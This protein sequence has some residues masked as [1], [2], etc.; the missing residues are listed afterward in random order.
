MKKIIWSLLVAILFA[1]AT[2]ADGYDEYL[3]E[4]IEYETKGDMVMALSNYYDAIAMNPERNEAIERWT[5]IED[6]M[7]EGKPRFGNLTIFDIHD[8][9][10]KN[11]QDFTTFA[12]TMQKPLNISIYADSL[13]QK[14]INY[15]EKN[16][17]YTINYSITYSEKLLWIADVLNKGLRRNEMEYVTTSMFSIQEIEDINSYDLDFWTYEETLAYGKKCLENNNKGNIKNNLYIDTHPVS[18]FNRKGDY[19]K[20][21]KSTRYI[22]QLSFYSRD[23]M[24]IT[25][26]PEQVFTSTV[27]KSPI[28][29]EWGSEVHFMGVTGI[30]VYDFTVDSTFM[31]YIENKDFLVKVEPI[32]LEY[33]IVGCNSIFNEFFEFDR[34][35]TVDIGE[36]F[37]QDEDD[38][39][40]DD[41]IANYRERKAHSDRKAKGW[42]DVGD[43]Y[44]DDQGRAIGLVYEIDEKKNS[45]LVINFNVGVPKSIASYSVKYKKYI[46]IDSKSIPKDAEIISISGYWEN[47]KE[48]NRN[49]YYDGSGYY[50]RDSLSDYLNEKVVNVSQKRKV[51][52]VENGKTKTKTL[53]NFDYTKHLCLIVDDKVVTKIDDIDVKVF[54]S[55]WLKINKD[56]EPFAICNYFDFIEFEDGSSIKIDKRY[57]RL[58]YFSGEEAEL[59]L[60]GK[61]TKQNW[62]ILYIEPGYDIHPG[63]YN[64]FIKSLSQD[65]IDK[66]KIDT[67]EIGYGRNFILG[68][69]F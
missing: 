35:G 17:E 9:W 27:G 34:L 18:V 5:A 21:G 66:Y 2:F 19:A 31:D 60:Q 16:I 38:F 37:L 68:F 69:K 58:N 61:F 56:K 47:E 49:N 24:F 6:L 42:Y 12:D 13:E 14:K 20:I 62:T 59:K 67:T 11:S 22:L 7:N 52:Y 46:T 40:M 57:E 28:Y 50:L 54:L 8:G 51:T 48:I 36:V 43:V 55:E 4:G 63:K 15:E 30:G 65:I 64:S 41:Y 23:G 39:H 29:K 33:G 10:V 25:K 45:G 3:K 44:V 1:T 53:N 32:V 26:G